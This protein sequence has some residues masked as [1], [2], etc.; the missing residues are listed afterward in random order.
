[1]FVCAMQNSLKGSSSGGK[2]ESQNGSGAEGHR[3]RSGSESTRSPVSKVM[4][5]FRNRSHSVSNQDDKKKVTECIL[6]LFL[7]LNLLLFISYFQLAILLNR[8]I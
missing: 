2:T 4:D 8:L 3:P 6:Y 7:L 1:M 5:M